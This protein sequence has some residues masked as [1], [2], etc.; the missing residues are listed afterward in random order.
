MTAL[1]DT[2]RER[3]S[4]RGR[5]AQVDC[6][7]L[8]TLTVEA[9]P[10]REC[11]ALARG[12]DGDR[13]VFYAA[14][15]ELQAAGEELRRAGQVFAPD[16]VMQYVSDREA[17]AG[18]RTVLALSGV[19]LR[20]DGRELSEQADG[21]EGSKP[22]D[23]AEVPD[24]GNSPAGAPQ[25]TAD[26]AD[27]VR[28]TAPAVPV[29]P[30]SGR[31]GQKTENRLENV[32]D[33]E[34]QFS[35]IRPETVQKQEAETAAPPAVRRKAEKELPE[36]RRGT[37]QEQPREGSLPDLENGGRSPVPESGGQASREFSDS[38]G[39]SRKADKKTQSLVEGPEIPLQNVADKGPAPARTVERERAPDTGPGGAPEGTEPEFWKF[40][41]EIEMES[42]GVPK[43]DMHE[44][45]SEFDGGAE[46]EMHEIK[47][48]TPE[49][50][51]EIT[52][53][54][55][56]EGVS[57]LHEIRSEIPK[58][59]HEIRSEYAGSLHETASESG[60]GPAA[61][62]HEITSEFDGGPVSG[63]HEIRSEIREAVH[64]ITSESAQRMARLLL[65]GL[66]RAYTVR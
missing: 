16:G 6:G 64:E 44:T 28:A 31:P 60:G 52:S 62:V 54:T 2:L 10:L 42:G 58:D 47:S 30:E 9:L 7:A 24:G 35:E 36:I 19:E 3:A 27:A 55:G 57:K 1:A 59:V 34:K 45:A 12:P 38:L 20:P 14:C 23:G 56:W 15:R 49:A 61:D 51:H 46:T 48:E 13:A 53:E 5:T 66:R 22:V 17:G 63:A 41:R 33:F 39:K 32:Q 43:A 50:V 18:A 29:G 4:R 25:E 65:E 37:V 21:L 8:G 40:P 11:A 26:P